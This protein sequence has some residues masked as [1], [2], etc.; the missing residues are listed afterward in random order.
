MMKWLLHRQ[1]RSFERLHGYDAAYMHEVIDTDLG[2]AIAFVRATGLGKYR[3]DVPLPVQVAAG[4]TSSLQADCGPCT[5]LGV[6]MA[7]QLGVPAPTLAKIIA[8]DVDA[9][10]PDVALGVRFARAV[11]AHDA[12]VDGYREEIERKWGKRAVLAL[13]Y[14]VMTSQLYPTLKYALGYG[15]ACTRIVVEGQAVIPQQAVA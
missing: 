8:G 12:A 9:L 10:S 7:L 14:A 6:G 3:K 2:A 1:L 11:L 4:I 13:T 15:Q 5:Q